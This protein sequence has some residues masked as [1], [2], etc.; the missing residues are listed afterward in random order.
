MEAGLPDFESAS[1][2]SDIDSAALHN[3]GEVFSPY[4]WMTAASNQSAVCNP[5][6][7]SFYSSNSYEVAGLVLTAVQQPDGDWTD[8]DFS[9]TLSHDGLRY[10]SMRLP[11]D[12]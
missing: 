7:C 12:Q 11:A 1:G 8:L 3:I 6:N 9:K 10:P 4:A 2:S 5:G